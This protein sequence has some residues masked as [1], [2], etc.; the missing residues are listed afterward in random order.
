VALPKM[1]ADFHLNAV[2]LTWIA[3]SSLLAVAATLL[4]SG[5]IADIYGRKKCFAIGLFIYTLGSLTA[6]LAGNFFVLLLARVIQGI[7]AGMFMTT[8]MAIL[9]SV[10]PPHKRGRAIG[11]Y[12]AAVYVGLSTGPA[13]GG[14]VIEHHSWRALFAL[15]VPLGLA[16]VALTIAYLKG[17]WIESGEQ[18]LDIRGSLL[19]G[20]AICALVYGTTVVPT[21]LGW[22]LI[23]S[24]ILGLVLFFRQQRVAVHPLFDVALFDNRGFTFSSLAALLNYSATF[25]VT[26]LISLYLQYIKGLSP[27]EAGLI[28]MMQPVTMALF[29]VV[30]GRISDYIEPRWLATSGMTITV[31]GML[32]FTGL[33]A[34]SSITGICATLILLGFGF[35]LFSSPNMSAIM[36]S[37]TKEQ[38]GIASGAVA[39]MRLMG[40]MLSMAIATVALA[41]LLDGEPISPAHYERF[42]LSMHIVFGSSAALCF[43]GIY[44]SWFRGPLR[45]M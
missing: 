9:S 6:V 42:L 12:V 3:T 32:L 20:A 1:Q 4:P 19:Y 39:T 29:S 36:G 7:G 24:G 21:A 27:R 22:A 26:F 18:R 10:F 5:K 16:S 2:Q 25:A 43:V 31:L 33:H 41:L 40:Q 38:Y 8:G 23:T 11:I 30:A 34:D 14:L 45:S 44:F 37:V 35:A 17:E 13:I 28:L 15:M